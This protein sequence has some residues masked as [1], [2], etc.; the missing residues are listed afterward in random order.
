MSVF[1]AL[2]G[3]AFVLT[4]VTQRRSGVALMLP[5]VAWLTVHTGLARMMMAPLELHPAVP[6]VGGIALAKVVSGRIGFRRASTGQAGISV[7]AAL[8]VA[9]PLLFGLMSVLV[10]GARGG[11]LWLELILVPFIWL[12]L[13]LDAHSRGEP[14][15]RPV[16]WTVVG[17]A[18]LNAGFV[19]QQQVT[20][21]VLLF[22][23]TYTFYWWWNGTL[24]RPLGLMDTQVLLGML[25]AIAAAMLFYLRSTVAA[26]LLGFL[27]L[28][29][30]VL[31]AART[32]MILV[33]LMLVIIIV[34]SRARLFIKIGAL[35]VVLLA[36]WYLFRSELAELA[37]TRFAEDS[38]SGDLRFQ[39]LRYFQSQL[40]SLLLVG[41]GAASASQL[42]GAEL[43]SSL[44]NGWLIWI[45]EYGGMAVAFAG[46]VL[47]ALVAWGRKGDPRWAGMVL[48]VVAMVQTVAF[49]STGA[50]STAVALLLSAVF[51]AH[52]QPWQRQLGEAGRPR[53]APVAQTSRE[54][55]R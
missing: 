15:R 38:G 12:A 46:G 36:G 28:V 49:S 13:L 54:T 3:A 44:E 16:V 8:A 10:R 37:F 43:G 1:L 20:G 26:V 33:G 55:L 25:T 18:V 14:V 47:T 22:P 35:S 17:C 52:T 34:G 27:L 2:M 23:G 21:T 11:L 31:A 45:F 32:S 48:F 7:F 41:R 6:L 4:L 51:A 50:S 24:P 30:V 9:V 39:A 5:L 40:S 42:R 19:I 53:Y 29:S